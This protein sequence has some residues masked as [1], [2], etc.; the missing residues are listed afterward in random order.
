MQVRSQGVPDLG[1]PG[2]WYHLEANAQRG[3]GGLESLKAMDSPSRTTPSA[4]PTMGWRL[5]ISV[6]RTVIAPSSTSGGATFS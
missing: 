4:R 1:S 2:S 3:C 6:T 5:S